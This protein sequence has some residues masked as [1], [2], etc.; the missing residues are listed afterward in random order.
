MRRRGKPPSAGGAPQ[1]A[2]IGEVI[3]LPIEFNGSELPGV[4]PYVDNSTKIASNDGR[5]DRSPAL[6]G[7]DHV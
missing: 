6:A 3:R 7:T 2:C 1:G 5:P 4:E